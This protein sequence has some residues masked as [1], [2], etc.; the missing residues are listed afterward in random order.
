MP[1]EQ[2]D[3][4]LL[5]SLVMADVSEGGGGPSSAV[6]VDG[7]SNEIFDDVSEAD[8]AVGRV[9]ARK[10]HISVQSEDTDTLLGANMIVAEPPDDPNVSV[11]LA[12]LG[13]VFDTRADAMGRI[14]AYSA[15]GASFLG[16]LYGNHITGQR[17]L[18]ILQRTDALPAVLSLLVLVKNEGSAGQ[19]IQYVRITDAAV[20]KRTYTDANGDY[21]RYLLSVVLS[22]AL[23][24]DFPGFDARRIDPTKL[25]LAAATRIKES[26]VADAQT[27]AG[28]VALDEPAHIGDFTVKAEGIFTQLVPSAQVESSIAD[29]RTNQTSDLAVEA[30]GLVTVSQVIGVTGG[31]PVS[32]YLGG[33]I[34]PGSL[35]VSSSGIGTLTDADG[36][37]FLGATQAGTVDYEGG[38]VYL[39]NSNVTGT[40]VF[41]ATYKPAAA[42]TLPTQTQGFVVTAENR[43]LNYLRTLTTLPALGSVTVSYSVAGRWYVLRERTDGSLRGVNSS[44]GAGTINRSTGTVSVTLGALPDTGSAIIFQWAEGTSDLAGVE[45]FVDN[46]GRFYW[47]FNTNGESSLDAGAKS[48]QPGQLSIAWNWSGARTAID[49]G[50]GNITGDATGTVNYARGTFRVSPN[51]LPAPGTV[52]NVTLKS[53]ALVDA[54]PVIAGG[55]GSFGATNITPGSIE[56]VVEGQLKGSYLII[57]QNWGPAAQYRITD[58]GAGV[59]QVHFGDRLLNVGTVNYGAGTFVLNGSTTIPSAWAGEVIAFDNIYLRVPVPAEVGPLWGIATA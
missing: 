24:T 50:N 44:Y 48:I 59:L 25:E 41:N 13:Q 58:N 38:F 22:D 11:T 1:I 46:A 28:V 49:D 8:R 12:S 47:P 42:V 54:T 16:Y 6:I 32:W 39:S 33:G 10:V 52:F 26:L 14:E 20:E 29:A 19:V 55:S 31:Q 51:V 21:E 15:Q 5:K 35:T 30:G 56:M 57:E 43:A 45:I 7:E 23:R 9:S 27:Y 2:T 4:K 17:A 36:V 34:A 40:A 53:A 18:Q 3:I 37:L